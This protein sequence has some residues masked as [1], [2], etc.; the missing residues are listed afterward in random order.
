M[1]PNFVGC[2]DLAEILKDPVRR[3]QIQRTGEEMLFA[4][5]LLEIIH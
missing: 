4:L 2:G 3:K 5:S 1:I